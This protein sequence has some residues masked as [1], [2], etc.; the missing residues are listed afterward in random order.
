M[1]C[2]HQSQADLRHVLHPGGHRGNGVGIETG[3]SVREDL[4]S[5]V[6]HLEH[7]GDGAEYGKAQHEPLEVEV[8]GDVFVVRQVELREEEPITRQVHR[9]DHKHH[10]HQTHLTAVRH[11]AKS[12]HMFI[13][14][15]RNTTVLYLMEVLVW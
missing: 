1:E 3:T 12:K 10:Q 11:P 4:R 2:Y 5:E 8:L 7:K 9:L 6:D 15:Q 14:F 13:Y